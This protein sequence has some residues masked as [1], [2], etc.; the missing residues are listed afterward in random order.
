M[1]DHSLSPPSKKTTAFASARAVC[2]FTR[3]NL[4]SIAFLFPFF[5]NKGYLFYEEPKGK[6]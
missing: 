4:F 6:F 3:Q 5:Y 2:Y 1:K